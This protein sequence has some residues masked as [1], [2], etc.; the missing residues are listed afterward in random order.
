MS[1]AC[2]AGLCAD[3]GDGLVRLVENNR[4][5]D[6]AERL[7]IDEYRDGHVADALGRY[8]EAGKIVRSPTAGE[9]F[10]RDVADWYA[11]LASVTGSTR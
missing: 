2:S 5:Q 9:S 11:A 1:A 10:D 4:Q 6:H 8:D 3:R 7:A